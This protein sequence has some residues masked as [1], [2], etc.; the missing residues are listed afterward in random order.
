MT[1]L[2]SLN[3]LANTEATPLTPLLILCFHP[4]QTHDLFLDW[5]LASLLA[6]DL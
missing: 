5:E 6:A 2:N 3:T 4:I 1:Y